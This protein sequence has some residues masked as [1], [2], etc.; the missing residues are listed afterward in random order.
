MLFLIVSFTN[1]AAPLYHFIYNVASGQFRPQQFLYFFPLPQGQGSFLPGV[2]S[3]LTGCGFAC[4]DGCGAGA[5][6][7]EDAP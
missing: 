5:A 6:P 1:I 7:A 2:L 3:T 4:C